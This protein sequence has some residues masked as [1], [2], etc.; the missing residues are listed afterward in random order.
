MFKLVSKFFGSEKALEEM[1]T[2]A[3]NAL[4]KTYYTEEEKAEDKAQSRSE[5][6]KCII[7]WIQTSKGQNLARRWLALMISTVWLMGYLL[8]YTALTIAPWVSKET[9]EKLRESAEMLKEAS[10]GMDPHVTLILAF[11]FAA[12]HLGKVIGPVLGA[13]QKRIKT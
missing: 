12:P 6:R 10:S 4:D 8:G 11:Y 2:T 7:D 9:G 5:I 13:M 3:T 1:V